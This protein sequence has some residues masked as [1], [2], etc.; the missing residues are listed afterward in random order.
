MIKGSFFSVD[1]NF[2]LIIQNMTTPSI[3]WTLE[4]FD[5]NWFSRNISMWNQKGRITTHFLMT[6]HFRAIQ[7][8]NRVAPERKNMDGIVMY[9]YPQAA[10][11][12]PKGEDLYQ[13]FT[14]KSLHFINFTLSSKVQLTSPFVSS[15]LST[16]NFQF[17]T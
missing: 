7:L 15:S 11:S 13:W 17:C 12:D 5:Q 9:P 6:W 16:R 10:A 3:F 2:V 1:W 4:Q 14:L 8:E